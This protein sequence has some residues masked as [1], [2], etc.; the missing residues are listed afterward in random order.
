MFTIRCSTY[1]QG[2]AKGVKL[3]ILLR[4][5]QNWSEDQLQL[6]LF[7]REASGNYPHC[8]FHVTRKRL[9]IYHHCTVD[10]VSSRT[11]SKISQH[12]TLDFIRGLF[13]FYTY[14]SARIVG[15]ENS[16]VINRVCS[17]AIKKSISPIN[18]NTVS[19]KGQRPPDSVP[20][21]GERRH[22]TRWL[23]HC[24][25][26]V[27]PGKRKA[28]TATVIP[29]LYLSWSLSSSLSPLLART[30]DSMRDIVSKGE[31]LRGT[32]SVFRFGEGGRGREE[33]REGGEGGGQANFFLPSFLPFIQSI[34]VI[35]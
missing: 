5:A 31:V 19:T 9:I 8:A 7:L 29:S 12:Q 28:G 18:V 33:G 35:F 13:I 11:E 1:M 6:R 27:I 23:L 3:R 25:R 26:W 14:Y 20:L 4:R 2:R 17:R 16:A 15:G 22:I 30:N 10:L 32:H 21:L 24:K 34:T